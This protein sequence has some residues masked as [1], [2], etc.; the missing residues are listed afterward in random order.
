MCDKKGGNVLASGGFGCVFSPSLKCKDSSEENTHTETITKGR[1]SKLMM[2]K[3]AIQEY[4]EIVKIREKLK[5]IPNYQNYFLLDNFTK[6]EPAKLTKRDVS[7]YT[8]KCKA[9]KKNG[10]TKDNINTKLDKLLILNMPN[11][12]IPVD[13]YLQKKGSVEKLINV[14]GSLIDLLQ[15]GILP[16]NKKN[17]YHCDIKD[18]NVLVDSTND[19]TKIR[20]IDWGLS[21]E[22]TPFKDDPFPRTWRNR[23]LQFNVPFSIIIFTDDFVKKYTAYLEEGGEI[24]ANDLRP[25]LLDYIH[26]WFKE[27]GIGHYK[28]INE[29][30]YILFS[31][32]LTTIGNE[33]KYKIIENEF[34]MSYILNYIIEILVHYTKFREDG[35]LNLRHYLDNLFIHI[36]D[37][38]GFISI[39]IPILFIFDDNY[40]DLNDTELQ[41]FELLKDILLKY[42]YSP[43]IELININDLVKDLKKINSLLTLENNSIYKTK[44]LQNSSNSSKTS[45][46]SNSSNSKQSIKKTSYN[47]TSKIRFEKSK[48]KTKR[49]KSFLFVTS[50]TTKNKK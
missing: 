31:R 16:M 15:N 8:K 41:I 38:W 39:Y 44:P 2:R 30:M 7:N 6:C 1:L 19:E 46:S 18:S 5:V 37:I 10:I 23:P 13:D 42:L 14:N 48:T 25:F 20:L 12:G 21:T 50:K 28:V 35:K 22:Y 9:L 27:R 4:D 45:N 17:V 40:E 49:F 33:S 11:G 43:R 36:I 26:F 34:T 32:D 47:K 3:N 29:I 24:N